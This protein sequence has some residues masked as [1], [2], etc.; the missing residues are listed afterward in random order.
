MYDIELMRKLNKI[1]I[2]DFIDIIK[3]KI[4]D[5]EK[6]YR[7]KIKGDQ[8]EDI[9]S[10]ALEEIG[11]SNDWLKNRGS[12]RKGTDI[13]LDEN[14][15]KISSKSGKVDSAKGKSFLTITSYRTSEHKTLEE[16]INFI[17]SKHED[18]IFS[19]AENEKNNF[20]TLRVFEKP[21]L[22]SLSWGPGPRNKGNSHVA[23]DLHGNK[24][25]M[26]DAASGQLVMH[27]NLNTFTS[28]GYAEFPLEF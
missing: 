21:D 7:T 26:H 5:H 24:F 2:P 23:N 13:V 15:L 10:Q 27:L 6:I 11:F 4:I 9:L 8:V 28:W 19:F 3:C 12:H 14:G 20:Y 17:S 18:I 16:K 25:S 1:L 22:A